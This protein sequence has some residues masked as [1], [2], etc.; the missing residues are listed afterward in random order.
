MARRWRGLFGL[1]KYN[2]TEEKNQTGN[3]FDRTEFDCGAIQCPG[4]TKELFQLQNADTSIS[5]KKKAE[6]IP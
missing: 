6:N 3:W 4:T 1:L 2:S 5:L